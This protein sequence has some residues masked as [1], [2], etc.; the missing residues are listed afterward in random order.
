MSYIIYISSCFIN[1]SDLALTV[2]L[3]IKSPSFSTC[4]GVVDISFVFN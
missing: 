4:V 2:E 3:I 1:E